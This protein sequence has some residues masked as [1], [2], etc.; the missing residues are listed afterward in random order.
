MH[1]NEIPQNSKITVIASINKDYIEFNT[2][3]LG[4]SG[5]YVL[6]EVIKNDE[7]K[8]IGFTSDKI[9]LDVSYVEEEKKPPFIW[10]NVKIGNFKKGNNAYHVLAQTEEGRRENRRGAYRLYLGEDCMLDVP[11]YVKATKVILKDISSTG[12]AF[13]YNEELPLGTL[14]RIHCMV[15][16]TKIALTGAIV[17]TQTL[18]NGNIVYGCHMDNFSKELEKFIAKKQREIIHDKLK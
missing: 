16:N 6:V 15:D 9:S 13:L 18:D 1:I 2:H 17:R 3:V 8:V 4:T 11:G 7:G 14:C 10:R 5:E 12:F